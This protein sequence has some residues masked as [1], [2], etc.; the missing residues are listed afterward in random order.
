MGMSNFLK[1]KIKRLKMKV[2]K[3]LLKLF[4]MI[5]IIQLLLISCNTSNQIVKVRVCNSSDLLKLEKTAPKND[6]NEGMVSD[7]QQNNIQ[8]VTLS[9]NHRDKID[10]QLPKENDS[11]TKSETV[12]IPD[13][14]LFSLPFNINSQNAGKPSI[15]IGFK[16]IPNLFTVKDDD[17]TLAVLG[18]IIGAVTEFLLFW[19]LP[20][21]YQIYLV[22]IG[23]L[24]LLLALIVLS[25]GE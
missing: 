14:L 17:K 5:L 2:I 15:N 22:L 18:T 23:L 11:I 7:S 3:Q 12:K 8:E 4:V 13:F 1:I 9:A 19:F 25:Q 10:Q 21:D 6:L 16:V 20:A 24:I